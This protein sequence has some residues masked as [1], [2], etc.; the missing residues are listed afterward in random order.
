MRSDF[1]TNQ[2][3]AVSSEAKTQRGINALDST[4]DLLNALALNHRPM[5]CAILPRRPACRLQKRFRT[6]SVS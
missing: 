1:L 6:S 3:D 2:D 5:T 4:G